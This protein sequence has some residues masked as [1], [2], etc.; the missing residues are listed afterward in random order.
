MQMIKV[1]FKLIRQT[2]RNSS[3]FR[4]EWLQSNK[5]SNIHFALIRRQVELKRAA[6]LSKPRGGVELASQLKWGKTRSWEQ[7]VVCSF[8]KIIL[9]GEKNDSKP[10]KLRH[11]QKN[12][13]NVS[14]VLGAGPKITLWN[15]LLRHHRCGCDPKT[16]FL[17]MGKPNPN[18]DSVSYLRDV[19]KRF[20]LSFL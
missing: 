9:G 8:L 15:C 3:A 10:N 7:K 4:R 16:V 12:K 17:D 20:Q 6:G 13:A 1:G 14:N 11:K 18:S 19:K 5:L 2:K